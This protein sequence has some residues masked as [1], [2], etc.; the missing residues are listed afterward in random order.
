MGAVGI[1]ATVSG[2]RSDARTEANFVLVQR[3]LAVVLDVAR[4]PCSSRA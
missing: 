1:E 4:A 3:R 2:H